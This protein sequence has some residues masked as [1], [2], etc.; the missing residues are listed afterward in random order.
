MTKTLI[1]NVLLLT[2]PCCLFPP[3]TSWAAP[4]LPDF[5]SA[6]FTAGQPVNN[7]YFPILNGPARIFE[8]K[9]IDE[10]GEEFTERFELTA[11]GP[12]PE[13]LG[14]QTTIQLDKSF[15][16]G[17]LV[18]ETFDYYAQDDDGNVWYMGED[19]TNYVYD[20]EGNLLSTN[21]ESAW[22]AGVNDALPGYMMP[23]DQNMGFNYYQEYSA[24]D[25]AMDEGTIH[26]TG[27][28]VSLGAGVFNNVLRTLETNPI[29]GSLEFNY[30]AP[31][32]GLIM[33]EEGL[34]ASLS[35][36]EL[37]FEYVGTEPVPE[38]ATMML[39]GTGLITLSGAYLR[40]RNK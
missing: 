13:L 20:D 7:A 40:R 19:V 4:V 26:A 32:I 11:M 8:A 34:D 31:G 3:V 27:L 14:I 36:P 18:E 28:T 38:P 23:A 35:N 37:V 6:T 39:F 22:L 25:N 33:V 24:L 16:D 30:Y 12:G 29:D 15:E 17:I 9:G 1:R 10:E 2:V 5:S 21:N